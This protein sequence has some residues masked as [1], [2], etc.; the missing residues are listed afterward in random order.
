MGGAPSRI[1]SLRDTAMHSFPEGEAH[2]VKHVTQCGQF[3]CKGLPG[4]WE[5]G[6]RLIVILEFAALYNADLKLVAN[7]L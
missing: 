6:N 1:E 3:A 2:R 5:G 4:A 7:K